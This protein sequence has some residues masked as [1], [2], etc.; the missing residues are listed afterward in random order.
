M[1]SDLRR[2]TTETG[3][4]KVITR[5]HLIVRHGALAAATLAG[6]RAYAASPF[7]TRPVRVIVPQAPGGAADQMIRVIAER[8]E[9][10]WGQTVLIEHKPGGGSV[11][12]T[13]TVARSAS[14]GYTIGTAGSSLTLNAVLR[15]NLPYAMKDVQPL[16]RIG[17]YT[18]VLLAHPSLAANDITGVIALAKKSPLLYGSNG[19]GSAAHLAGELLNKMAGIEMQHVPY[20]GAAKMYT[21]MVGG[22][23]TLG[24]AIASSADAF[25]KSGQL[26]VIGVTQAA[27]SPLYPTWPAIAE[28][29]PGYEAVNWA[30]IYAPAGIPKPV[31]DQLSAD[32]V[33]AVRHPETRK[34][35]TDMGID[36]AEQPGDEFAAFI[37]R[38]I[39]RITPVS[40]QIGVL[41]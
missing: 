41:E 23:L 1:V 31:V 18:T 29:V 7:P 9:S 27:R 12:A 26:K 40:K 14:D 38:D 22:R 34:R 20:N 3:M 28:S 5:R 39:E 15:K 36:V 8:L 35:L 17:Y 10:I 33:K 21:D 13:Q 4:M 2:T 24:F 37:A 25:V 6:S 16:A 19:V 11:L 30:G 32:I